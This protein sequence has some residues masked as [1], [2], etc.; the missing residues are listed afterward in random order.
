VE[1]QVMRI[2]EVAGE[3]GVNI[4]TLR[5]Y[6]RRGLLKTPSR[7]PSGYR[8]YTS[9]SVR[10]V[11][12]IKRAQQL[13]FTLNEVQDLLRLRDDRSVPCPEV[14]A[15]ADAKVV[16]IDEKI[17]HLKAMKKALET[18]AKSCAASREH[19]C[20]LLEALDDARPRRTT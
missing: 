16:E 1:E 19:Q 12:F 3:A 15:T 11:R 10:R 2:G 7:R 14:R 5:F 13:G 20:P 9:D 17:R 18:L 4:Q 8:E 6:E